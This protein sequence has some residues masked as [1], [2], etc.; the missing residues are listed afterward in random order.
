MKTNYVLGF[1]F[2]KDREYVALIKKSRPEWQ[3]GLLN[4]IGGK[5]EAGESELEA[6]QR[7]FL[8]EAGVDTRDLDVWDKF[9]VM[10][11]QGGRVSCFRAFSD[12][13]G[14]VHTETDEEVSIIRVED[15]LN[16]CV[17][18]G[19]T[20]PNIPGLVYKA[21]HQIDNTISLERL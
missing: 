11:F 21:L 19:K 16:S 7:E 13:I 4:G 9:R 5:I 2:S 6:M 17:L 20:I 1:L 3:A 8:E 15:L 10:Y 12:K 18:E 14:F